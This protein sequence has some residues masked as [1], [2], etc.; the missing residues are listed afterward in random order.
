MALRRW[1]TERYLS[2]D[3]RALGL[4]RIALALTLLLD[5]ARR[6]RGLE[7]WY[8]NDGLLPN[9]TL[10]WKPPFEYTF[11]LFF[12]ASRTS[13]AV[14]GFVLCAAAYVMLLLGVRTRFAQVA[15]FIAVLSLHGRTLFVQNGGDAVL[16]ELALWS[17]FLPTGRRYS[18]DALRAARERAD[19]AEGLPDPAAPVVSLAV[20]AILGQLATIYFFNAVQKTGP[21][22]RAG[23]VV[24]YMLHQDCN[25]TWL[26]VW[27]RPH[28][29]L[30]MSRALTWTAWGT[31]A[32]LPLLLLSP[33]AQRYTRRAAVLLIVLLHAGFALFL[34]LGIFVPAMLAFTP[35]L[36]TAR[37]LDALG[38]FAKLR[39]LSARIA[40]HPLLRRDFAWLVERATPP[41]GGPGASLFGVTRADLRE[42]LVAV[43]LVCA[44][45]QALVENTTTTHFKPDWQPRFM[46]ATANYLQTFQGWAMYAPDPPL[47]DMNLYVDAITTDGRHVDPWNAAASPGNRR[48]GAQ[49][50]PHLR[51]DVMFFAYVL[52]VPW[53]SNYWTALQD[54]IL[55]YPDRTKRPNDEIVSFEAFVIEQDS[56]PPGEQGARN[57]R[58]TSLFKYAR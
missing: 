56:P 27:L 10:L 31:E 19:G 25:N 4:G 39:L 11:S 34:N 17:C 14:F 1:L 9:H 28:F 32:V 36:L 16:G 20:F 18:I 35:N 49:I 26:A 52:R 37:D 53:T 41:P 2:A 45:S 22:W 43:L 38:G 23:T 42:G 8:T 47:G 24:H 3:P 33:F 48:T 12:A 44:V 6:A 7:A 58:K 30:G 57:T 29:T 50:L 54:W 13:E 51:Q 15:S 46:R 55:R 5:L 21:T 40:E